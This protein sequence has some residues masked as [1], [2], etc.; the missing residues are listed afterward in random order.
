M[1]I[2]GILFYDIYYFIIVQ[3][4]MYFLNTF[5]QCFQR[6]AEEEAQSQQLRD[7][8]DAILLQIQKEQFQVEFLTRL[9]LDSD[10]GPKSGQVPSETRF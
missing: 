8:Q 5:L 1:V 9:K 2:T 7:E 6:K 4:Y 3:K 10:L